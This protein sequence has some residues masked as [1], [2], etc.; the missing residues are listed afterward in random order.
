MERG[1]KNSRWLL[2]TLNFRFQKKRKKKKKTQTQTHT[3]S[4]YIVPISV[5]IYNSSLCIPPQ[6]KPKFSVII[7]KT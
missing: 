1:H 6:A 5:I 4:S 3:H 2:Q 7:K